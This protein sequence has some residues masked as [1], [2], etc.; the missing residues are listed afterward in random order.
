MENVNI[1]FFG[2][3]DSSGHSIEVLCNVDDQIY[4]NIS[5]DN[6]YESWITLN[7]ATDVQLVRK[8][9]AEISKI[10]GNESRLH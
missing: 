6:S 1:K 3:G 5:M 10:D 9:K 8:L 2:S 7:K 4:I